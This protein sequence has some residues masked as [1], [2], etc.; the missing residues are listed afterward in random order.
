MS[1][2]VTFDIFSGVPNPIVI[3]DGAEAAALL[4]KLQ[5]SEK[6]AGA[7][8]ALPVAR[9]GYRGMLI[10]Q[11]GP[12]PTAISAVPFPA[13][14]VDGKLFAPGVAQR[15]AATDI[16]SF[17]LHSQGAKSAALTSEVV[18][19]I[20]EESAK[21][22][23]AKPSSAPTPTP[24]PVPHCACGPLYEPAWWNDGA[25]KQLHNNCYNYACNYRTDTFA[26]PG[27]AGGLRIASLTCPTVMPSAES[28]GLLYAPITQIRCPA[29]GIL[30][31]LVMWPH[32]DFHWLRLGRDGYWTQKM[33]PSPVT[34]VDNSG[35]RILDPRT[36]DRGRYTDFCCFM[37]AQAGHIKL[38]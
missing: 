4:Q 1:L 29:E 17:V 11:V 7:D 18:A 37:I 25:Q 3:L 14:V 20:E 12:L 13:R 28:D 33:G 2:R 23:P 19:L 6:L 5:S 35:Y 9:L 22:A 31:A 27:R 34:N 8:A 10:E 16:E 38:N 24:A 32:W 15:I 36:A 26:Q 30:V 21:K